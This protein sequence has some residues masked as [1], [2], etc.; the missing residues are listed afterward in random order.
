MTLTQ[1]PTGFNS[2]HLPVIYK[3][4]SSKWPVNSTDT[5]RTATQSNDSGYTKL[6]LSGDIKAT[7][8]ANELEYVKVEVNGVENI[9]QI[10]TWYSDTLITIDLEYDAGNSI[11]DVQYYYSNYHLRIKIYAGLRSGH[12]ANS[13]IYNPLKPYEELTEIKAVPDATGEVKI[14]INEILK[15]QIEIMSNDLTLSTLPNDINSFCEFYVE[16][17]EAYDYSLDG[18]TLG[19]FVEAYTSD[20]ANYAKAVNSKLAFKNGNGGVMSAYYGAGQK[21]L[22][23]FD[24]PVLFEGQYFEMWFLRQEADTANLRVRRYTNG[25]L[26]STD[27]VTVD[28]N[29]EGV[30]RVEITA[31]TEDALKVDIYNG[32]S[33][34]EVK[35][36]TVNHDCSNQD[37][38]LTW[39]NYLGGM[40][41]WLFTAEKDYT[42]DIEEVKTA[43]KNIFID[44]PNSWNDTIRY[45][46]QRKSREGIT[47]RT[48]NLTLDQV[49]GLKYIRTSPFVQI[50]NDRTVLVDQ[51]SFT[52]YTDADKL[53]SLTFKIMY[54]N[55][56]SAQSL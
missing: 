1:R 47:I 52:V 39:K 3:F 6:S 46:I 5:I 18:Y 12:Y 34:S 36:I 56:I 28:A 26:T 22:T 4:T 33:L 21:F 44:W 51:D 8:S 9:Y 41:Y 14:N 17:A 29:D 24:T 54:T 30:Y 7:G 13:D 35:D 45:E 11:G 2:V 53:Y 43:E 37:I 31:G 49:N 32:S 16:Y 42:I 27:T 10:F 20:S 19:T 38:Y 50:Y 40:D 55:E 15:S 48:Q 25:V 23:L